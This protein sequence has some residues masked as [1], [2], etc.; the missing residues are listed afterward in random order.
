MDF[1]LTQNQSKTQKHHNYT[2]NYTKNMAKKRLTR[3]QVR[4]L[5][6]SF[7]TNKKLEPELK[8]QLSTQ[9]GVP[10]RQVAIWYQNKRA[11]WKTQSLE[12]DYNTL[13]VKLQHALLEKSK[14]ERQVMELQGELR[15][16]QEMMHQFGFTY[17]KV[18]HPQAPPPPPPPH[19]VSCNNSSDEGGGSS[20]NN[21]QDVNGGE[22]L[23]MEDLYA[24]LIGGGGGSIW[25]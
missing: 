17:Q 21:D 1:F 3:D 6:R 16:A 13:Q 10:P 19:D 25:T 24:F 12:I 8:L 14:L 4:L 9:L 20:L 18:D 5:E 11:R 23:Q 7:T 2:P 22:V 15:R